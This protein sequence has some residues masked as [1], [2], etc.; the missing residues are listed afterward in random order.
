MPVINIS[1]ENK[2]AE[3]DGTLYVCD[4]S[5]FVAKFA[6]DAEWEAYENK[7]AR[8]VYNNSYVD[9]VFTG[10]ECP[11]PTIS[12]TYFFN[13]GVYAG[14]LH[15]TT[16]ARVPC[17]KSILCGSESES[18]ASQEV[19][20]EFLDVLDK[21]TGDLA[22]LQ[23][24]SK[25]NLVSAINE[26]ATS[27]GADW[28]QNDP[29][30]KDYVK[31]RP[32]GYDVVTPE[33]IISEYQLQGNVIDVPIELSEPLV[34]GRSYRFT[35]YETADQSSTIFDGEV[36]AVTA[37]IPGSDDPDNAVAVTTP[38]CGYI[39]QPSTYPKKPA[40]YQGNKK[41]A[42]GYLKLV[43]LAHTEIVKISNKY[44]I[45]SDFIITGTLES[46]ET[47]TLDKTFDQIQEAIR[48]GKRAVVHIRMFGPESENE[49]S[50]LQLLASNSEMI[51]FSGT[52]TNTS[53]DN[54]I[55]M[56]LTISEENKVSLFQGIAPTMT[57]NGTIKQ[58]KM[59]AN[60]TEDMQIATKQYVD[61]KEFILKS[62]T[63]NSAKKFKITVDD[64]GT[65]TTM[66]V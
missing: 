4:N 1:V 48:D 14:N 21:R 29:T 58:L 16:P 12:G 2:I 61:N 54:V 37:R 31:N 63:L 30:A 13:I 3:A 41:Y 6:F 27:G 49:F 40:L 20:N 8:F 56:T 26:V 51:M 33:K 34:I 18:S 7:T 42:F 38:S 10:N 46:S 43:A 62:T 52:A 5:D 28:N 57:P 36:V 22:A 25:D 9:V 65:I 44:I 24:T 55:A 17:K 64:S 23:T 15:T 19:K 66:E 53:G 39:I 50:S 11:V 59:S 35:F 32:G 60:P 45:N 47:V